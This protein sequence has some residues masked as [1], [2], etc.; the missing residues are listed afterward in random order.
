MSQITK[1]HWIEL[2]IR[3]SIFVLTLIGYIINKVSEIETIKQIAYSIIFVFF[4]YKMIARL[5][6]NKKESMGNQKV[7]K[8]NYPNYTHIKSGITGDNKAPNKYESFYRRDGN[9]V[10]LVVAIVWLLLNGI[11]FTLYLNH[12]FDRDLLIVIAMFF[13]VCDLICILAVC[14]FQL[15]FMRN[16]CCNT[17]RIYNWDFAMMFTPLWVAPSVLNY[18]LVLESLFVL[19]HWEINHHKYPER[20]YEETNSNLRCHN[21]KEFMCKNKL[22]VVRENE[23]KFF[24][25]KK[26]GGGRNDWIFN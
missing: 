24:K 25:K 2:G 16:K 12:I 18:I 3:S 11:I 13:S 8:Q 21:C 6:P 1:N 20:F 19:V 10:A 14:P 23:K 15:L 22:R 7:F 26:V 4:S 9:R 5:I 17:C